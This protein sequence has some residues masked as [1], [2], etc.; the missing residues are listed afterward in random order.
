MIKETEIERG[1]ELASAGAE[2][3]EEGDSKR[4]RDAGDVKS[5]QRSKGRYIEQWGGCLVLWARDSCCEPT[6]VEF[7]VALHPSFVDK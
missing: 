1:R 6:G 7:M 2:N 5:R 3:S 4:A